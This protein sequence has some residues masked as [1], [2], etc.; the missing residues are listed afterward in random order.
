M[1]ME[2]AS[3][4]RFVGRYQRGTGY[5]DDMRFHNGHLLAQSTLE[6]L[7]GSPGARLLPVSENT[8]SLEGVAPMIVVERNALGEVIGYVQQAPDSTIA[9]ARRLNIR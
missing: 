8:F 1:T 5:I 7:V 3:L 2:S 6:A 4:A 9:R